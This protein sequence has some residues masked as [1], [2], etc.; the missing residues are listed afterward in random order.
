MR[1][2]ILD[3]ETTGLE[4]KQGHKII[5]IGCVEMVDRRLTGNNFHQY[6]QPERGIDA[7]AIKVHGITNEFL[8]D[9]PKFRDVASDFIDY[10]SGAEL[11]IHNAAFDVGFLDHELLLIK[12]LA[13]VGTLCVVTD[14]LIMAKKMHPGQ[15]NSLDALCKRYDIDNSHRKLHGALLDAEI[16]ADVYLLMTGGQAALVLDSSSVSES[17]ELSVD[18]IRRLPAN[19]PQ[20]KVVS[21]G[22][23]EL[24]G[25]NL[26]LESMGEGCVWLKN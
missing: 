3:T 9:K 10:V 1:Q 19:R 6:L 15:R 13:R 24:K 25:H 8:V 26:Q 20:L 12:N 7:A 5:E 16:L 2:I 14:T 23:L 4:P 21:A 22:K 11:I 18:A 17:G